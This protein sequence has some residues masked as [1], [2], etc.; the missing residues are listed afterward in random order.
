MLLS[1]DPSSLTELNPQDTWI[2]CSLNRW[3][4]VVLYVD[5]LGQVVG[6]PL[7]QTAVSFPACCVQAA[8]SSLEIS[9]K[10]VTSGIALAYAS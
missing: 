6:L 4:M 8:T 1:C 5:V 9:H 2:M 10:T 3:L 7:C